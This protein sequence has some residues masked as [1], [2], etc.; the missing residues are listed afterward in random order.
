MVGERKPLE[1][2][3]VA[4]RAEERA[5]LE[6]HAA[7]AASLGFLSS[8]SIHAAAERPPA[9]AV[10]VAGGVEVFVPLGDGVDLGK[11]RDVLAGRAEKV[12]KAVVA[13]EAKLRAASGALLR[14]S[15]LCPNVQASASA[16]RRRC[17]SHRAG[18]ACSARARS[19]SASWPSVVSARCAS[20][21]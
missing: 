7:R 20:A 8:L 13:T 21:W 10:A 15:H 12:K 1:A 9:S 5:L 4:P 3:A 11:L 19:S 2:I 6:K 17:S 18:S 16:V 14:T